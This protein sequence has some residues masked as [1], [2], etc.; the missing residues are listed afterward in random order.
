MQKYSVDRVVGEGS[1][2]KALLCRRKADNR[3]CIIKQISL[4]K[5][6]RSEAKATEQESALL[7]RLQHPN[8]VSFWESFNETTRGKANLYIVMDFADGG[9]LSDLIKNRRN[10]LMSE[11]QVVN[12]A[13]QISL[14]MKH[15]HDRKI[16]HRDLK[17]GNIFLTKSGVVKLGDFG[18]ARVLRN[19]GELASTQIG[20]PYFMS[21]EIL[22]NKRYNSKTDIWSL[23]CVFF[24]LAALRVPFNGSSM[25]QLVANII[26]QSTPRISSQYS[27]EFASLLYAMLAKNS[28]ER[29]SINTVLS[30]AVMRN[31][32]ANILEDGVRQKEFSHT[33]LHG[34]HIL[35]KPPLASAPLG[36]IKEESP[37]PSPQA[38]GVPTGAKPVAS[39]VNQVNQALMEARA[40]ANAQAQT[41]QREKALQAQKDAAARLREHEARRKVEEMKLQA[42]KQLRRKQMAEQ[43]ARDEA[44]RK[45]R[46]K[47]NAEKLAAQRKQEHAR[48]QEKNALYAKQQEAERLRL[49]QYRKAVEAREKERAVAARAKLIEDRKQYELN[50]KAAEEAA[51]NVEVDLSPPVPQACKNV[52]KPQQNGNQAVAVARGGMGFNIKGGAERRLNPR[53]KPSIPRQHVAPKNELRIDGQGQ[54]RPKVQVQARPQQ[55]VGRGGGGRIL[56]V[57]EGYGAPSAAQLRRERFERLKE[58]AKA[59]QEK[60]EAKKEYKRAETSDN[61]KKKEVQQVGQLSPALPG[62]DSDSDAEECTYKPSRN[63]KPL[64]VAE[65]KWFSNLEQQMGNLKGDLDLLREGRSP[66]ANTPPQPPPPPKAQAVQKPTQKESSP[67]PP[68][69]APPSKAQNKGAKKSAPTKTAVTPPTAQELAMRKVRREEESKNLREFVRAQRHQMGTP[70]P[71]APPGTSPRN[72]KSSKAPENLSIHFSDNVPSQKSPKT[73]S[74]SP[75]LSVKSPKSSSKNLQ[76]SEKSGKS[77]RSTPSPNPNSP[78]SKN[79]SAAEA[80]RKKRDAE[81]RE[82]KKMI[83]E[84][85]N[86]KIQIMQQE[87]EVATTDEVLVV[88]D[89]TPSPPDQEKGDKSGESSSP[90]KVKFQDFLGRD[91]TPVTSEEDAAT[92]SGQEHTPQLMQQPKTSADNVIVK[93]VLTSTDDFELNKRTESDVLKKNNDEGKVLVS[94]SCGDLLLSMKKFPQEKP[95]VEVAE[96]TV[97]ETQDEDEGEMEATNQVYEQPDPSVLD[98]LAEEMGEVWGDNTPSVVELKVEESSSVEPLEVVANEDT[99]ENISEHAAADFNNMLSAMQEALDLPDRVHNEGDEDDDSTFEEEE[100]DVE[101]NRIIGTFSP[102]GDDELEAVVDNLKNEEEK[103]IKN[104]SDCE[105]LGSSWGEVEEGDEDLD[106]DGDIANY[107]VIDNTEETP[108]YDDDNFDDD[109]IP[110]PSYVSEHDMTVYGV[111]FPIATEQRELEGLSLHDEDSAACRMEYIREFLEGALGEEQFIQAYRLLKSIDIVDEDLLLEQ[112]ER[113]VG[114]DG[115]KHM[116]VFIQLI[117]IEEKFENL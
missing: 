104:E 103:E 26:R 9:D 31:E 96:T 44:I 60:T 1:F 66:K 41:Q 115:L 33:I 47:E 65:N 114:T 85:R 40:R 105:S 15:V 6:S 117:T 63:K 3:K 74:K 56:V 76:S 89:K 4:G 81:R 97:V 50:K 8:I 20:T 5:M 62:T 45:R 54:E 22:Q 77:P 90:S 34:D 83:A 69:R 91:Y 53:M 87:L 98:Q 67:K 75:K 110:P 80:M 39:S 16:L 52:I 100:D 17:S 102:A 78:V 24:E 57:K 13:V 36:A 101:A 28:K 93:G 2:G 111:P 94:S 72:V 71:P 27:K 10:R 82:M 19:T 48:R 18:I 68:A 29:P 35:K 49:A 30:Q 21:P 113:I 58:K 64:I 46:E 112:M 88:D 32:I 106:N 42:A 116:D 84:K 14:A 43:A 23:G 73:G 107:E 79:L 109:D 55:Q 7:A 11:K 70:S 51:K 61:A 92:L 59:S 37:K 99:E 38:R 25:K 95:R 86:E 12:I 108:Q